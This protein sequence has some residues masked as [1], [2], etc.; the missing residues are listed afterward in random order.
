M[1]EPQLIPTAAL[2]GVDVGISVSESE[3]LERLGLT[4][5][6]CE[7]AIAELARAIVLAGGRITYGGRLKPPGFTQIL[8]DEVQKYAAGREALTVC[9]S[10]SEYSRMTR[11]ELVQVDASFGTFA[12]LLV[13]NESSNAVP[14]S[15]YSADEE[16]PLG[17]KSLTGMRRFVAETTQARVVL[18]GKLR[19]YAGSM[20]G[21]LEELI[22]SIEA[23]KRVYIAG[24]FGGAAAAAA[25]ELGFDTHKWAPSSFP[26][27][28]DDDVAKEALSRLASMFALHGQPDGLTDTERAQLAATH[29]AGDIATLVILG[30][31]RSSAAA[32]MT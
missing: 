8:I 10:S 18:G 9:V 4:S 2:R 20:P 25:K 11:D 31:A 21:V 24:G 27:R 7:I 28:G 5:F 1:T 13:V 32:E 30:I 6:H 26:A 23:D 22:A 29:R 19:D 17:A 15:E 16:T 14:L 3:D 12:R